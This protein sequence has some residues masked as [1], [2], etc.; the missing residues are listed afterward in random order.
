MS[1]LIRHFIKRA[2]GL[3]NG[4]S[5]TTGKSTMQHR[6]FPSSLS[7]R[8]GATALLALV[9]APAVAS[10]TGLYIE[11]RNVSAGLVGEAPREELS[12]TYVAYD[13]MK[14]A[15]SDPQGNDMILDPA[16]DTMTFLNHSVKE[17]Y[18][19]NA[20]SMMQGMSQPGIDQMRAM[21]EQNKVSV[22]PT[23]ETRKIN[24]WNCKKYIVRKTGMVDIEQEVW[25]T[26]DV[27]IDLE[28][29]TDLMSMA[30]PDGLLGDSDA[31]KAQREEMAKIKGYT[32]LSKAKMDM[33]GSIMETESEVT[34]I[35]EEPMT[36]DMFEIPEGYTK[37]EMGKHAGGGHQ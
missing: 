7:A 20:K 8:L 31:A 14:V 32:I 2:I 17:Y 23:D 5:F 15:S 4:A 28:R 22:E 25:A 18:Q 6:F 1:I 16:S 21:M 11:T 34:V 26:E 36:A 30:G 10:E 12:K 13:K 33:M 9:L 19:I 27:D 29:Y 37:K 3:G 35:R 24:D